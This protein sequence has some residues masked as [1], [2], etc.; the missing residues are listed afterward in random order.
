[1]TAKNIAAL[2]WLNHLEIEQVNPYHNLIFHSKLT[3]KEKKKKETKAMIIGYSWT[4]KLM[5]G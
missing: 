4:S 1:M 3:V 5:D 2:N